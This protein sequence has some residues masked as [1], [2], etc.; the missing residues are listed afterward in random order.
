MPTNLLYRIKFMPI[1]FLI[2]YFE[3]RKMFT[4]L[5]R[6]NFLISTLFPTDIRACNCCVTIGL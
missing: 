1:P 5:L 3:I 4:L 2:A 6:S